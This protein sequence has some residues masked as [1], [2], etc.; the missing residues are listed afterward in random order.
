M[1]V[2]VAQLSV[3]RKSIFGYRLLNEASWI[4]LAKV[5]MHH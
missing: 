2:A 5:T 1:S 3:P 4:N